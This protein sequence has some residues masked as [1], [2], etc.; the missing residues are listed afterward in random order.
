MNQ[1]TSFVVIL[2]ALVF[3][4]LSSLTFSYGLNASYA[5]DHAYCH[6]SDTIEAW[7]KINKWLKTNNNCVIWK[8]KIKNYRILGILA[9][10]AIVITIL[11]LIGVLTLSAGSLHP[12]RDGM[13]ADK[14]LLPLSIFLR[15]D[16]RGRDCP[17][18]LQRWDLC[19]KFPQVLSLKQEALSFRLG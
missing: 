5:S 16:Y 7:W 12:K 13:R 1:R 2:S 6:G 10:V 4:A 14:Y 11:I 18:S 15:E 9:L 17:L 3:I 8:W 19:G